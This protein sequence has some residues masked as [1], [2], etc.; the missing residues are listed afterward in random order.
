MVLVTWVSVN[1]RAAPLLTAVSDARSPL[2]SR[3]RRLYLCWR[4][5]PGKD[6]ER[7]RVALRETEREL[8]AE[9]GSACPEIIGES[10]G[11]K[12]PPTD[13]AAIRPFAERVLVR[14]R[15]ENPEADVAIL[16][17]P[18]TPAMHAVW[19]L[20]GSTGFVRGPVLL[21]QT[22]DE[23]GRAAGQP[24]VQEVRLDIDTWLSR[25]R[26]VRP[27]GASDDDDGH[28]W[29]P[30]RVKSPALKAALNR[31]AEWAPVR[32]PVLLLGERGTGK[33]TLANLL[34]ARSPFQKRGSKQWSTVVCGQF[35]VNPQLA[36]SELFGHARG[37]FT[38]ATADRAGLLELADGD[39]LFFDEI[40][41]IDR[42][43]QRLLMAA[44]EG[45]GF[46]RLGESKVRYSTFRLIC[47]SNLPLPQLVGDALDRDFFDRIAVFV[48]VVPPLRECREDLPDAWRQSLATARRMAGDVPDCWRSYLDH[49][50]VL[51]AVRSHTLPGNFRDLHRAAFHLLAALTAGRDETG[52]LRAL[53]ESLDSS[54]LAV[55][56]EQT[57]DDQVRLPLRGDLRDTIRG[58]EASWLEAALERASGNKSEAARLVGLPR[59]TFDHRL[60]VTRRAP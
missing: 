48:L 20:L 46:Q 30:E 59:K 22:A 10:W 55:G 50:G 52:A 51:D 13:H 24:P 18:G 9:L 60:R 29:N 45:R 8:R 49:P 14:A 26:S 28:S 16:L 25:F 40:G 34:R 39:S 5:T 35:R 58:Y 15:D 54:D 2:R 12:S 36:R 47:A 37:A 33:T 43:T 3:V 6:G 56:A 23:R 7:E 41:D 4:D 44:V 57:R 32:A 42:D 21:L 27:A 11:T 19:L 31:L 1:H 53:V 17:S 38:G